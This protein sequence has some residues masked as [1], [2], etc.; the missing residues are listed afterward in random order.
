MATRPVFV[1]FKKAPFVSAYSTEFEW[2]PGLSISQKLR[3]VDA[4]HN[5]YSR[6]FP[7]KKILEISSKSLEPEGVM[8]SVF[9]LKKYVPVLDRRV[10]VECVFQGGKVFRIGGPFTDLYEAEPKDAKRDGRLKSSGELKGFYF[11]GQDF[12]TRPLTAFYNWLYINALLENPHLAEKLLEY[13]AF[14]DIEFNPNRSLNCQAE[15][16]AVFVSL[17]ALGKLEEARD[18]NTFYRLIA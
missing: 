12:P 10:P 15:A 1:P 5:A 8:L 7:G 13:D 9:N 6:R 16:A 18:I 2:N 4:L 14:T 3:N 11:D 17:N